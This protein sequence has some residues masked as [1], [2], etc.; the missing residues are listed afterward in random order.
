MRGGVGPTVGQRN[1]IIDTFEQA[2]VSCIPVYY[3]TVVCLQT[4]RGHLED[5]GEAFQNVI[6]ILA[7][8]PRCICKGDARWGSTTPRSIIAGQRP[9]VSG[10][11]FALTK[12]QHWCAG[13]VY[14]PPLMHL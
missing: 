5:A 6:C 2:I 14:Y 1:P 8:T 10:F 13:L 11:G 7:G 12:I 4:M 9:E 3:L